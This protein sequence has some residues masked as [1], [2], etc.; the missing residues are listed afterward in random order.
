MGI[1]WDYL[2]FK[3]GHCFLLSNLNKTEN[4]PKDALENAKNCSNGRLYKTRPSAFGML[5]SIT[6]Q[7]T[8]DCGTS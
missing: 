6:D 3:V 7:L 4:P 8:V 1:L 5:D 2:E